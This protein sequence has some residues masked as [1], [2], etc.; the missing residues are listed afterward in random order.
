MSR[1]GKTWSVWVLNRNKPVNGAV[2]VPMAIGRVAGQLRKAQFLELLPQSKGWLKEV[3]HPCW[4]YTNKFPHNLIPIKSGLYTCP[5]GQAGETSR[6]LSGYG[7]HA[8]ISA[9]KCERFSRQ[10]LLAGLPTRSAC[11]F[12][13]I[14][15]IIKLIQFSKSLLT[16]NIALSTKCFI[17]HIV[18]RNR[19]FYYFENTVG[20]YHRY[21]YRQ[22]KPESGIQSIHHLDGI[23]DNPEVNY[24]CLWKT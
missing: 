19:H 24:F 14:C 2:P 3:I 8:F 9:D 13:C 15:F 22:Q 10:C 4:I 6:K 7:G 12:I 1:K 23:S 21:H 20:L 17:C 18:W 5:P 11:V 16:S